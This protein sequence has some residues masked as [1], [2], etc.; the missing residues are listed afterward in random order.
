MRSIVLVLTLCFSPVLT[1]AQESPATL[2]GTQPLTAD[3]PLDEL[4]VDG[5][6][7]FCLKE[8][9]A[10]RSNREARW[11]RDYS[12]AE[13]YEKG[14]EPY[15]EKLR[16]ILGVVDKRVD[17]SRFE[18]PAEENQFHRPI[19]NRDLTNSLY[20]VEPSRWSVLPGITAEGLVLIPQVNEW[21]GMVI[22]LPDSRWTPETF[23]I[24]S[25]GNAP[26]TSWLP[27]T[28]AENGFLVVIPT[29][30]SR[31]DDYSGNPE[32]AMTNQSHREWVYRSAFELGRH[33]VGYEVQKVLAAVDLLSKMNKQSKRSLPICIAG[34]GDGGQ[35]ALYSA[36][37]DQRI[38]SVL[39]SGYF[40]PREAVWQ[41]PIDRNVWRLLTEFGDAEIA[42]MIAPRPLVIEACAVPETEGPL[43]V[44]PNRRGGAAPGKIKT[45][46]ISAVKS[47]FQKAKAIYEK[48]GAADRIKLVTN[49]PDGRGAGFSPEAIKALAEAAGVKDAKTMPQKPPALAVPLD[50]QAI[51]KRQVN[52]AIE[53]TQNLLRQSYKTRDKLFF[54]GNSWSRDKFLASIESLREMVYQELIGKLPEPSMPLNPRTRK[55]LDEKEYTGYEVVLDTYPDVIAAG[56]LLLPKGMKPDEKRPVVVCQH[57]LEGVPM[58][59]IEGPGGKDFPYYSAFA[60]E[61]AKRGFI[62]YAP[63]NPYRGQDRFRTLQRKSNPLGRSLFSYIIPQRA[64]R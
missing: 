63:Q 59:T 25:P 30:I 31:D 2:P 18:A 17:V 34:T 58:S 11:K 49:G 27:A 16:T 36:A 7:R 42:G 19:P 35:I 13:A 64:F 1:I 52:E 14:L 29:L 4:M 15:R 39:I 40:Q 22:A 33:V 55:V 8:I 32:V 28:M 50:A 26:P 48:L 38:G 61:L 56:I 6:D 20:R 43:P 46:D 45:A 51:Q 60:S 9:E 3:R 47:E 44:K 62:T 12:S 23:A 10:A 37:L 41:E 53:F 24:A 57:G 5:I 21:K 54:Q